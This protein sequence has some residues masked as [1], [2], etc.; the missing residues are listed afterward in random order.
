[1]G[2]TEFTVSWIS[3]NLLTVLFSLLLCLFLLSCTTS[4]TLYFCTTSSTL[5]FCTTSSTLYFCTTSS[6]LYFEK[7][8][9]YLI[10][11]SNDNLN[12]CF[13]MESHQCHHEIV[14]QWCWIEFIS[15]SHARWRVWFTAARSQRSCMKI[16]MKIVFARG[17]LGVPFA[18]C[19]FSGSSS[20]KSG[21][22]API[23]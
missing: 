18:T 23:R 6:T 14:M 20:R 2:H 7:N 11:N 15:V 21:M 1:M 16:I 3:K 19:V 12:W 17:G 4:S 13:L 10:L 9:L 5:Y 22:K 8:N